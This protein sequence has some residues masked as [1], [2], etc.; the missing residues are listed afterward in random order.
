[1]IAPLPL[2]GE[3]GERSEPGEGKPLTPSLSPQAGRGG[4]FIAGGAS[5]RP[6]RGVSPASGRGILRAERRFS[7]TGVPV[8]FLLMQ[9]TFVRELRSNMTDAERRLWSF[10]RNRQLG[11]FKFRRQHPVGA[12]VADFVC[13]ERSLIIELDGGQHADSLYDVRR[14]AFLNGLGWQVMRFWNNDVLSQTEAVLAVILQ[15]LETKPL[16]R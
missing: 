3:G 14:T 12:F 5:A 4:I 9:D 7:P 1:M 15:T 8:M 11:G 6:M 13:V 2:V 10:L 16:T